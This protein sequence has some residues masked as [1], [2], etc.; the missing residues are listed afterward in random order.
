MIGVDNNYLEDRYN[1][2]TADDEEPICSRCENFG[3]G[4]DCEGSC[5]SRKAW[6]GYLRLEEKEEN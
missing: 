4:F 1:I 6:Y 5:G 2:Y 3:G